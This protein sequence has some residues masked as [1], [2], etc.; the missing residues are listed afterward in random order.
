VVVT[1]A[2]EEALLVV[3]VETKVPGVDADWQSNPML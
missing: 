2:D 1:G 3:E